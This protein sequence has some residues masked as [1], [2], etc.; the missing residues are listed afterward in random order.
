MK[1]NS[2][3]EMDWDAFWEKFEDALPWV[4]IPAIAV[5]TIVWTVNGIYTQLAHP[6]TSEV[7][8]TGSALVSGQS[9]ECP[10]E[11]GVSGVS[12]ELVIFRRDWGIRRD[13][14]FQCANAE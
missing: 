2:K 11:C 9:V 14:T 3:R 5:F 8:G 7:N 10:C 13:T 12:E 1:K 4:F 6:E